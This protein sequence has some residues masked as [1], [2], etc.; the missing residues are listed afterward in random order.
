MEMSICSRVAICLVGCMLFGLSSMKTHCFG[1]QQPALSSPPHA[2]DNVSSS[3][4][5]DK[6]S[7]RAAVPSGDHVTVASFFCA[8]TSPS[9]PCS[10]CISNV[11]CGGTSESTAA[12]SVCHKGRDTEC[13][14]LN[15][16]LAR[17]AAPAGAAAPAVAPVNDAPT[18]HVHTMKQLGI[19][20]KQ[21]R[22]DNKCGPAYTVPNHHAGWT[23]LMDTAVLGKVTVACQLSI[24]FARAAQIIE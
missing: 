2:V 20:P 9:R 19:H 6:G 16:W 3:R 17:A 7:T 1:L 14:D 11:D 13:D 8:P 15:F 10:P 23:V 22:D 24:A 4:A 5:L 21:Y 18:V 12:P